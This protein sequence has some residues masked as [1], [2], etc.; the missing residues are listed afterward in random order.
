MRRN[1]LN[2]YRTGAR[3]ICRQDRAGFKFARKGRY[4]VS[5]FG[6]WKG[7]DKQVPHSGGQ[8]RSRSGAGADVP[9]HF[10][11]RKVELIQCHALEQADRQAGS[12]GIAGSHRIHHLDGP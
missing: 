4:S 12:E 9:G 6:Y 3:R 10:V 7:P 11:R 1:K 2:G 5:D 8:G